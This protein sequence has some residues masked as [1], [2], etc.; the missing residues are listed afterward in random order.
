MVGGEGQNRRG[1]EWEERGRTGEGQK[2]EERGRRAR[3]N[4]A[5][6]KA[7]TLHQLLARLDV[8]HKLGQR[9]FRQHSLGET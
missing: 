7:P 9:L 2:W 8:T 5:W 1:Q 4:G 6:G 3:D